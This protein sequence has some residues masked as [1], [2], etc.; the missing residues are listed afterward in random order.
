M[1]TLIALSALLI[2]TP[3]FAQ[4]APAPAADTNPGVTA[5]RNIWRQAHNYVLRSAEQMPEDKYSYRPV[6]TVR[7]FAELLGH[8][9]GSEFMFCAAVLGDPPRAE[10]AIE[11]TAKTKAELVAA[12]KESATYCAKAYAISDVD[13]AKS[14]RIFGQNMTGLAILTLNGAHTYEHY[15]NL[16]TYLRINGMVPPSSQPSR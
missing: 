2:A 13:G 4:Q 9:A 1:K 12:L 7:T 3:G 5:T 11:K 14:Q 15:G 6:E 8:V 10:D 16:V